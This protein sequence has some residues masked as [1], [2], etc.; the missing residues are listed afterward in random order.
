MLRRMTNSQNGYKAFDSTLIAKF[1]IVRDVKINIRKGDVSVVLLHFARW[2]DKNIEPLVASDTGGYNPRFIEGTTTVSNHASGTAIDLRW[3]K[4]PRGKTDSFTRSQK[5]KIHAQLKIYEG[6]IRWGEDYSGTIDGMHYEI[7]KPPADVARIA[8]KIA[9][10]SVPQPPA[11][12]EHVVKF[13]STGQEVVHI[14][15]FLRRN[16][17]AYRNEVSVKHG[18]VITVDGSFREQTKAWVKEFQSRT[19]LKVNG[20]VDSL[21]R[22]EMRKYGYQF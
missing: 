21:T 17:P 14:Q 6:V 11:P 3:N 1:A 22:F 12:V 20:E 7:N 8:K 2:Y 5:D 15:D 4:H 10:P 16:F 18:R 9:I 19:D 13:G